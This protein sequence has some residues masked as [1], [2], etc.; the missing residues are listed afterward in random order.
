LL[1]ADL[2]VNV[3][4]CQAP[5]DHVIK[6]EFVGDFR[7]YCTRGA[8]FHWVEVKYKSDLALEGARYGTTD[9]VSDNYIIF[10]SAK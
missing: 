6:L 7:V 10:I 1:L 2:L 3:L 8:C 5:R 9:F 4:D